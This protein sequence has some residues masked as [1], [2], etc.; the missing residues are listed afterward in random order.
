MAENASFWAE[1]WKN[2]LGDV[3][4]NGP[5]SQAKCGDVEVIDKC[6][7]LGAHMDRCAVPPNLASVIVGGLQRTAAVEAVEKWMESG[8]SLLLLHGPTGSGKSLAAATCFLAA[9]ET[10]RWTGGGETRWDSYGCGFAAACDVARQSYFDAAG[11]DLVDHL[12]RVTLLVLD[13][14]G[15]EQVSAPWLATLDEVINAR[16]GDRRKRTVLTT[17]LSA[18]RPGVGQ[19]SPFEERYGARVARRIRES[20]AVVFVEAR[21]A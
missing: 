14:V 15:A 17:N 2:G 19:V 6:T 18:K 16:F 7:D 1:R 9:R 3:W 12:K 21:A 8:A 20:G 13:D 11:R 5:G 10:L 4:P